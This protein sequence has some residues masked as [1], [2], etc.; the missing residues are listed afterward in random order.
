[1]QKKANS[2][3]SEDERIARTVKKLRKKLGREPYPWEKPTKKPCV[4]LCYYYKKNGLPNPW[5]KVL[6]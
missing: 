5:D 4:G 1:M 3:L 6:N 2:T